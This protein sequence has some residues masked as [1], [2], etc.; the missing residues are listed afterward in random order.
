LQLQSNY[1]IRHQ[2][3]ESPMHNLIV[4]GGGPAGT[5]AALRARELGASVALVEAGRL[6]GICTNDGCVP[7]RVLAKAA[8]LSRDAGSFTS[9]GLQCEPPKVDF[10][11]V[12]K[13]VQ[14]VV[15]TMHEKKQLADYL[16]QAGVDVHIDVGEAAF[17]DAH[18]IALKDG[19]K[20]EAER[21]IIAA[22]GHARRLPFPGAEYT[23][24]HH[25]VWSMDKLPA[26]IAIVGGAATGCQIASVMREFG[27]R[28]TLLEV[29]HNILGTED[30][31]VSSTV[32]YIFA[33]RGIDVITSISGVDRVEKRADGLALYY[34]LNDEVR[35]ITVECVLLAVGWAAN[36]DALNLASAGV[37]IDKRGF[38]T[39]DDHLRTSVA[40]IF[41]AGDI[42][43]HM[44]LV[45]SGTYE[46]RIAAEN[47]LLPEGDAYQHRIVPHGGF[48]DPEYGSVGLTEAQAREQHDIAVTT[49]PYADVDRAVIDDHTEGSCKLIVSRESHRIL[50]AHIVGEQAL[51]TVQL[52]AAGMAANM[53]VEALSELE[54][55]YPTYAAIVGLAARQIV[56]ELGVTPMH[57][58]WRVPGNRDVAEWERSSEE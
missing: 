20:L 52:V 53:T 55:A 4:I 48:T 42:T 11:Q 21:F 32:T 18:T 56:R 57:P 14:Q 6:G 35:A 5:T 13:R 15:Y 39:V 28:V 2:P 47:A 50:G 33:E 54:I 38:I 17:I 12:M 30:D 41:A 49:V 23:I 9:Y 22:G 44:M 46:A 19:T 29:A 10:T 26:S 43:G 37:E 36:V 27:S 51:E 31:N 40:H 1:A 16:T 3:Q 34:K 58:Q 25:E 24:T 7:T 45:Q 8:R